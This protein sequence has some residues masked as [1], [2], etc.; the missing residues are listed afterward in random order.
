MTSKTSIEVPELNPEEVWEELV[1]N[2]EAA[3]VDVRTRPEWAFVGVA[4]LSEI[5]RNMVLAEWRSFPGM[6]VNDSFVDELKA[7]LGRELPANLYFICRSGARSRDAAE[8]VAASTAREGRPVRCVNVAEGFEGDLDAK[9]HRANV[10]GWKVR[11]L[12]WRQS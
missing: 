7:R 1:A 3:L 6:Q 5:D 8:H 4:D 11:G 9:G 12:S 2:P 10:N